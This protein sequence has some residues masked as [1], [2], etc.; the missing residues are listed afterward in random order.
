MAVSAMPAP[1]AST[2]NPLA[3]ILEWLRPTADPE[4]EA[5]AQHVRDSMETV[6]TSQL[7]GPA[8]VVPTPD[9]LDPKNGR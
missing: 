3:K 1:Y 4:A 6:R 7:G 2:V 5:E 8:N 9:V